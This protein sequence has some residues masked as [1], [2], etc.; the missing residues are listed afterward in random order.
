MSARIIYLDQ[1]KWIDLARSAAGP[2]DD[3]T[4]AV[5]FVR[6]ARAAGA[7]VFPLSAA[8]YIESNKQHDD[9]R[10][11]RLGRFM[12]EI[13][14]TVTIAGPVAIVRHEIEMAFLRALPHRIEVQPFSLLGK[15]V[16]HAIG[17]PGVG[18][19]I[20]APVGLLT[21]E[22]RR[23]LQIQAQAMFEESVLTGRVRWDTEAVPRGRPDFSQYNKNFMAELY[24]FRKRLDVDDEDLRERAIYANV[25]VTMLEQLNEVRQRHA[26]PTDVFEKM[27]VEGLTAFLEDM[28]SVSVNIHLRRHWIANPRLQAKP[29]D[30]NDWFYLGAAVAHCDVVVAERHFTALAN[31]PGLRKRATVITDVR[32]LPRV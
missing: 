26:I 16:G 5:E 25:M 14:G 27:G 2:G 22:R 24:D 30:H 4:P 19:R 13:S 3:F 8:H 28:P 11:E 10:F 1:N 32:D 12:H 15:G 9:E 17:M 6:A 18:P 7:A 31:R 21:G 20:H 29:T 23:T